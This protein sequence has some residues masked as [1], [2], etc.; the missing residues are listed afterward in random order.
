[1]NLAKPSRRVVLVGLFGVTLFIIVAFL[2][3]YGLS[4][5]PKQETQQEKN[6]TDISEFETEVVTPAKN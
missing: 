6:E 4:M 2:V 3:Y 1:M 5:W